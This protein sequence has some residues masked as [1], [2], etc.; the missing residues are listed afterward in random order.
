MP[1]QKG[2][3]YEVIYG[4]ECD[5]SVGADSGG[6]GAGMKMRNTGEIHITEEKLYFYQ[7]LSYTFI[8]YRT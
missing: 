2:R 4:V 1:E 8:R 3:V 7:V 6:A 5:V